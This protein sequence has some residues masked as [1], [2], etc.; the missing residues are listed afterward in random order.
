MAKIAQERRIDITEEFNSINPIFTNLVAELLGD[1]PRSTSR[2]REALPVQ[3]MLIVGT[4]NSTGDL[5]RVALLFKHPRWDKPKSAVI[6]GDALRE[7]SEVSA[8]LLNQLFPRGEIAK[9]APAEDIAD[10][11]SLQSVSITIEPELP[12]ARSILHRVD[13]LRSREGIIVEQLSDP[14]SFSDHRKIIGLN[15]ELKKIQKTIATFG[16][17]MEVASNVESAIALK[18]EAAPGSEAEFL[19]DEI[20]E[21]LERKKQ[22]TSVLKGLLISPDPYFSRNA[23]L[24]LRITE[25]PESA[26]TVLDDMVSGYRKFLQSRMFEVSVTV[27]GLGSDE[28]LRFG[29]DLKELGI[30]R[31]CLHVQGENAY[32]LLRHEAGL[33]RFEDHT[34]RSSKRVTG[35]IAVAVFPEL[36]PKEVEIS[37]ADIRIDTFRSGGPGGQHVNKSETAVRATH[38]PS[39]L[40][41]VIRDERSQH[42]NREKALRI[43]ASAYK[44]QSEAEQASEIVEHR[45]E[46][47]DGSH[48]AGSVRTYDYISNTVRDS[49]L[50]AP[51]DLARF[52][53]GKV[54]GEMISA[55]I[56]AEADEILGS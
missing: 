7:L 36:E 5:S 4:R 40:S 39:E 45:R 37:E 50:G 10:T 20:A 16:E 17:I 32:G 27:G 23:F 31:L 52:W 2:P 29:A 3:S 28:E 18:R 46:Q 9:A 26:Y 53:G 8:T 1:E 41:V 22:L 35:G 34:P 11:S 44:A 19:E 43:L 33:H 14:A 30:R 15:T 47:L 13:D 55:L 49:R 51:F 21:G 56:D 6:E 54:Q 42:Y 25:K 12:V 48:R 38:L 24:E